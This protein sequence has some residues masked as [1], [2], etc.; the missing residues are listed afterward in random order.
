V[1]IKFFWSLQEREGSR[2]LLLTEMAQGNGGRAHQ[3][4]GART[5]HQVADRYKRA[6][7]EVFEH[8]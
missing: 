8:W 3:V 4:V 1:S 2:E 6:R 5:G 7:M